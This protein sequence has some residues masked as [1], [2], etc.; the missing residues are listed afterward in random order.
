[1]EVRL[2]GPIEAGVDGRRLVLGGAKQRAVLAMLALRANTPVSVDQLVEGLWGERAPQSAPKMVQSYVSQLRKL[3][4]DGDAQIVTRGRGYELR[5]P[6]DSVD[7]LRLER[8]VAAAERDA[9]AA[10]GEVRE[11]LSL[12]RG[13]PLDDLADEPFAAAEIR[14]LEELWLRARE[15]ALDEALAAGQHAAVVGELQELVVQHPFREHLHAQRMLALYRC[16]RQ[17][18]ALEAYRQ[19]RAVLVGEVGVEP[20]PDLQRLHGAVLQHDV[21]LDAPT[22]AERRGPHL[23]ADERAS[24]QALEERPPLAAVELPEPLAEKVRRSGHSLEGER[25]QVTVLFCDVKGSMELAETVDPELLRE[26]LDRFLAIVS[27]A[28]HDYEGTVN[29]FT[30]DGA[31]ALFGAPIAHEDHARRGCHAALRLQD[32]L[33]E[34]GR[35]LRAEHGLEFAVRLGLNS[36]EVVAAAVGADLQMNYT[37][38]GHT[39]GLARRMEALAEP[40]R[41]YLTGATAALVEGY[42]EL[43]DLGELRVKGARE[44]VHAYGLVGVRPA[45]TRLDAAAG[46]GLS[47]LVG[48]EPELATLEAALVRGGQSGHV[49]GVVAEPGVGKSRLCR[50]FAERCRERGH[51]VTVGGGVAHR[52]RV[53]L[54]P[55]I[56]MLR[57]YFGITEDDDAQA[58]RTKIAGPLRDGPSRDLL[59]VLFDFLGVPDPERPVPA[60][61]APEA[62]QRALFAA[63]RRL[64]EAGGGERPGVLVVED[65]HWLDPGSEAFLANLVDSLPGARTLLVVNFRPEYHADWMRRSYYERL[66]LAPLERDQ[67][68][69]LVEALAGSDPSLDGLPELIAERTGGNPFF[70][71]EVVRDLVEGGGLEGGRGAYRLAHAIGEIEIPAT[72]RAVLAGRIDRLPGGVKA[73]L[74]SAAVIGREFSEPVLQHVTGLAQPEL[75]ATLRALASTELVYQRALYPETRYAF[76]HPL[77]QE[78]AYHSQLRERRARTHAAAAAA[79]EELHP[80]RQ[81]ELSALLSNHW[82]QAGDP[83]QAAQWGARAAAWAGR[84]HPADGLRHWRR[85]RT[86]VR[87]E[88]GSPESVGLALAACVGILQLGGRLGLV[89]DEV[90]EIYREARE[91]A[92]A[93]GDKAAP[94]MVGSAYS[95]ALGMAGRLEEA[96]VSAREAQSLA[97]QAGNL[98]LQVGVGPAV[99]LAIAGRNR[100]ALAEFDRALEA[101]GDDLQLGRHI[102]GVSAVIFGTMY[103]GLVLADLGRLAEARAASEN[104]LRLAREHGDVECLGW[105]HASTGFLSFLTGEPGDGLAHARQALEIAERLGS[106]FSR[107]SARSNLALAHIAREEHD[108]ALAVAR[109][110]LEIARETRTGLQYEAGFLW[111]LAN[112]RLGAGD[113]AGARSAAAEGVAT[114]AAQGTRVQQARCRLELGRALLRGHPDDAAAELE[115]ALQLAGE[116]GPVV[117][118]HV[119]FA[120]AELSA[121][122]G[123]TK[124]HLRRLEHANRLFEQQGATGHARR[125]AAEIATAVA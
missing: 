27:E 9:G 20:G 23:E 120:L 76:K 112:A 88:P 104:A 99:W 106:S 66:P 125:V 84:R 56:E 30:G 97:E 63:M 121:L 96:I 3:L 52:R 13:P 64:V 49:V 79:L 83:L 22:D 78:V 7:A 32:A 82:E 117:I 38:I 8:L 5:L 69:R 111:L 118:P 94:V 119:V 98:E 115:G 21:A 54:L 71:E 40:G 36:G 102:I 51:G 58:A 44:P 110:A 74:Q 61:M 60:Q 45:R 17:A 65:L 37:A 18:E 48:R 33:A 87:D 10:R 47:P 85:V 70:V 29:R 93:T 39:V 67:T 25:K 16:G 77:T 124:E 57:G 73:V 91:L 95:L 4:H 31:M 123:D 26:L 6:E 68:A 116:D 89:D 19:A 2:L 101:A 46:R 75:A 43:E 122:Q 72:V 24:A 50:E 113:I 114:A 1:M 12:W 81:D 28:V 109:E 15:L 105:A 41:A 35:E 108:D 80:D 103:R 14:R 90:E 42:F 100:E 53:P 92:A 11:A 62:R 55:V 107:V 34:Y 59:P 86:M